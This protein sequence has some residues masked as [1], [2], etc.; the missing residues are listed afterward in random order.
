MSRADLPRKM[1]CMGEDQWSAIG[2]PER[3]FRPD[4]NGEYACS[5][6]GWIQ[7]SAAG[8]ASEL[9]WSATWHSLE[10][11]RAMAAIARDG[12]FEPPPDPPHFEELP[13]AELVQRVSA[14]AQAA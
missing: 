13:R 1:P 9:C 7:S 4:G 8:G 10:A 12:R 5:T 2:P 11:Y 6:C 3:W 14:S